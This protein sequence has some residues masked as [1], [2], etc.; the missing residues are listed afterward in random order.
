MKV[1]LA[2]KLGFC[3]GVEHAIELVKD[4]QTK[5]PFAPDKKIGAKVCAAMRPKGAMMR[6][7]GNVIILMPAVGMDVE[8]LTTLL[9]IIED[10]LKS[11]LPEL[12]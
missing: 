11:D 7:L 10:T 12:T 6:P 8:I 5:E 9:D 4:K 3:F 1:R 2:E